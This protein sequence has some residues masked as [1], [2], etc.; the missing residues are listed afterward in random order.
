MNNR[1]P[2]IRLAAGLLSLITVLTLVPSAWAPARAASG[3][4]INEFVFNHT[5]TDT[6]EYVEIFGD[7]NTDY[8]GSS[9]LEIEGDSSGAG[10][11]DGVWQVGTTDASGFWTTGFLNNELEN[12]TLTLL[13]VEGFSGSPGDD[14]DSDNDGI[15]DST[16]WTSVLDE[17]AVTDGGSTDRTYSSV[18]LSPGYDGISFTPGGAS[19]IPNGTDT[20]TVNDW[21][22]NDFDGAGLIGFSG[23][24]ELGEAFNTPGTNN[25]P[26]PPPPPPPVVT[27]MEI[28]G[29][30]QFSPFDGQVVETSGV[31]TLFTAN[32]AN[33]WLQDPGGDGN[34][35]TSDGIFVAGGGFPAEG[36]RPSV[37]DTIRIIA[38]V[39]EQQFGNALPLTRLRNVS[40]IEV[41]SSGNPLPDPIPLNDLPDESI[42]DGISFWEPLEGMLVSAD[43]APVVAAT[44]GFGEFAMLA[45]D[46]A[47]PGSG[48]YPQTQQILLRSLGDEAV[49]YNPERILVDD[50]SLDHAIVVVPGDRIRSLVGAVDYTFGNYKLQPASFDVETHNLPNLPA[51]TRSGPNGDTEVTTFNVENLFDLLDEPGKDDASS[52]PSPEELETKLNKL[53]MAIKDELELP[54]IL[55]VQEV[56]NTEILQELGDRVN[57]VA[58]TGYVA[59]SFETSDARGIEVGFLWDGNRVDLLNAYQLSGPD[60]EAAFGPSSPSPG[61]EPLVGVFEVEGR[62]ITIVGNHFKSKS[63]DDPLFGVNWPPIRVTEMQRKAQARVVRDFVNSILDADP[64]ALMM[65]AGD[66]NDFQFGEP[67]EGTDHPIAILEGIEGGAP[68]TDLVN[69]EKDDERY[70]YVFDGNSQV[71][72]HML[73]SPALYDL[74]A[75]VDIL[76][77]DAGFP[78]DLGE[79]AATPLRASDHDPLEGR[80]SLK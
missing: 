25:E 54:E 56:E 39:E 5:G 67:G 50:S 38:Q 17:V 2:T 42:A 6:N 61:R 27:I 11:I 21:L 14:L 15:L 75:A 68:L 60:V 64:N 57:A 37:G 30:S 70:T 43:N 63:G 45:K 41:L 74:F 51:S 3:L 10:V 34:P 49:D 78:S 46:D 52:T 66:L 36:P 7:P 35:A 44:S 71:L 48:F 4:V 58:G 19:R 55:V 72:D 69:L 13:L 33:F 23:T 18:V 24:P 16:P 28:Q 53:S 59:T 79:D 65:V 12:G 29:A 1:R 73:V 26:V 47:K 9:L 22:R 20:D 76:H 8:P 31:V 62:Q 80:F 77:F 32:G 40:L